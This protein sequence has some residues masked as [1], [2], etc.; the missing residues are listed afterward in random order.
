MVKMEKKRENMKYEQH[1]KKHKTQDWQD[2]HDHPHPHIFGVCALHSQSSP[3][4]KG[5]AFNEKTTHP[6]MKDRQRIKET[7][8]HTP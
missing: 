4:V 1:E 3:D 7:P 2:E 6:S 8:S 5:D